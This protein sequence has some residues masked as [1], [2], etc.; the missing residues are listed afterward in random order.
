MENLSELVTKFIM[1]GLDIVSLGLVV[2]AVFIVAVAIHGM[3]RNRSAAWDNLLF[4]PIVLFMG[5]LLLQYYPPL[6]MK[7]VRM[8]VQGSRGEAQLLRNEMQEWMPDLGGV[9]A[10][11]FG[12]A[13]ALPQVTPLPPIVVDTSGQTT[14][15]ISTPFPTAE[16]RP[17]IYPT[18]PAPPAA[19]VT[20]TPWPVPEITL[21]TPLPGCWVDLGAGPQACP[22][23]PDPSR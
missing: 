13:V 4:I 3:A 8:G 18:N 15:T 22:P 16:I 21:P 7:S 19:V 20:A 12:D 6:V 17:T 2:V 23:T 14:I 9:G 11:G 10:G 5:A 1:I